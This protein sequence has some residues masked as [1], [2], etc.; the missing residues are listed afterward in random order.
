MKTDDQQTGQAS[1]ADVGSLLKICKVRELP[2]CRRAGIATSTLLR[3]R[4]GSKPNDGQ[5]DVVRR[6]IMEVANEAGTLP[7]DLKPELERL[8]ELVALPVVKERTLAARVD[9]LERAV[10]EHLGAVL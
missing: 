3:W 1:A 8:R 6:A 2:A 4:R 7:D 5:V 9:S 10:T